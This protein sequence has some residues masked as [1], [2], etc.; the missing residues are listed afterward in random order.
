VAS[1]NAELSSLK[2]EKA[3]LQQQHSEAQ[4]K[5]QSLSL[6]VDDLMADAA[7]LREQVRDCIVEVI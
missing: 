5:A 1:L 4:S 3:G 6:Q 7:K 2:T